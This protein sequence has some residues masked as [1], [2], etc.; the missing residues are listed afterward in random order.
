MLMIMSVS[1][2]KITVILY[3]ISL[4]SVLL[5]EETR[6]SGKNQPAAVHKKLKLVKQSN[7]ITFELHF[8][9]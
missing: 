5:V 1:T 6:M 7:C 9:K 2:F 3:S 8:Y 4:R